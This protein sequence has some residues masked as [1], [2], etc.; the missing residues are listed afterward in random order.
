MATLPDGDVVAVWVEARANVKAR[1]FDSD[2]NA[3]TGELALQSSFADGGV[4]VVATPDGG[5]MVSYLKF[6]GRPQGFSDEYGIFAQRFDA[7]G[8]LTSPE[9][10]IDDGGPAQRAEIDV[11]M[12][13]NGDAVVLSHEFDYDDGPGSVRRATVSDENGNVLRTDLIS[14]APVGRNIGVATLNSGEVVIVQEEFDAGG[15]ISVF[16]YFYDAVTGAISAP[17][18]VEAPG[19]AGGD[20]VKKPEVVATADGGF[21]VSMVIE[22]FGLTDPDTG[23][24]FPGAS[25]ALRTFDGSGNPLSDLTPVTAGTQHHIALTPDGDLMF[26]YLAPANQVKIAVVQ[27]PGGVAVPA[28]SED[29]APIALDL[30]ADASDVDGDVL[31]VDNL[32]ATTDAGRVVALTD[33]GGG[34][35]KLDPDQFNDLASGARETV[36]IE[37]D[38]VDGN[39]GLATATATLTVEGRNDA[40]TANGD[41]MTVSGSGLEIENL[42]DD[43]SDP[44]GDELTVGDVNGVANLTSFA[45]T[46]DGGRLGQA[47]FDASTG[48]FAFDTAGGFEG[49]AFGETDSATLNYTIEDENGARA[50][51]TVEISIV[52]ENDAPTANADALTLTE[53]GNDALDLLANDVDID[54]DALTLVNVDGRNSGEI[55]SVTSADG[56]TGLAE[57]NSAN[58]VL[59]FATAGGFESLAAGQTDTVTLDY[60]IEDEFGLQSTSTVT[61]E[62]AG[63]NDAPLA[64]SDDRTIGES[65]TSIVDLLANDADPEGDALTLVNVGGQ[66][67]NTIFSVTSAGG[68]TGLAIFNAGVG[69]LLFDTAGGFESLAAGQTDTVTLDYTIADA[70]GLQ[71]TSTV[72]FEIVGE[73]DAPEAPASQFAIFESGFDN[74]NLLDQV[75]DIDGAGDA[76][77]LDNVAG[78]AAGPT[79]TVT[80]AGGRELLVNFAEAGSFAFDPAGAF[81]D[82]AE[83]QTD[84]VRMDYTVRDASGETSTASIEI[85][86]IG[87]NSAP[88][89]A[90]VNATLI[91]DVDLAVASGP[92]TVPNSGFWFVYDADTGETSSIARNSTFLNFGDVNPQN[93]AVLA[94]NP[95]NADWFVGAASYANG[96][97][98]NLD[99]ANITIA[100]YGGGTTTFTPANGDPTLAG[101]TDVA[102]G[103]ELTI[104][105]T[106]APTSRGT[107][108]Y[109]FEVLDIDFADAPP[110]VL[111]IGAVTVRADERIIIEADAS[112]I[113]IGDAFTL[114]VVGGPASGR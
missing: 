84:V 29:D 99:P 3:V 22:R 107:A 63:E 108:D 9:A 62:I 97:Q 91:E 114:E 103:A 95:N 10:R 89:A 47:I 36:T 73:N 42:L 80:S 46:T 101:F 81:D 23:V 74:V 59:A 38:V 50:T 54:G 83:G 90:D 70:F 55:F 26:G 60:T 65:D 14:D 5:F 112:D 57:F 4:S 35:F 102:T 28:F 15:A 40:P 71:S 78:Q 18:E 25:I 34:N 2:G 39:G 44:D 104:S 64:A 20:S 41:S 12:L 98:T 93:G 48:D 86:I 106:D 45:V 30:L 49:L 56:R 16:A 94:I 87:E 76:L 51:S 66:S 53:S 19:G 17:I 27:L 58:G 111:D 11:A 77:F 32:T 1:V 113:D 24:D 110:G 61:L 85:E 75:D 13:A 82:L 72:T 6:I 37:Y 69:P 21:A 109:I 105:I 88:K 8:N 67:G 96:V 68:L 79:F 31:A 52:G 100:G 33:L 43:D 92:L 7:D